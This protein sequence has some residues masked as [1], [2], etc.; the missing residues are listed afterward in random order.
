MVLRLPLCEN[1]FPAPDSLGNL[2]QGFLNRFT[3]NI[4]HGSFI[5]PMWLCLKSFI[6]FNSESWD[7]YWFARIYRRSSTKRKFS[8]FKILKNRASFNPSIQKGSFRIYLQLVHFSFYCHSK[9]DHNSTLDSVS[10]ELL[11]EGDRIKRKSV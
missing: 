6:A 1:C 3:D 7:F 9:T 5:S 11:L 8:P 2:Y 4:V 10:S